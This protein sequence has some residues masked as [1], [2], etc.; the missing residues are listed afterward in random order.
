MGELRNNR[1]VRVA[2]VLAVAVA[3][4]GFL[5]ISGGDDDQGA[6]GPTIVT[7][8]ELEEIAEDAERPIYWAGERPGTL[9]V[10]ERTEDGL[11]YVRYVAADAEAYDPSKSFL[12][13]GTYTV[14]DAVKDLEEVAEGENTI[15]NDLPDG[16]LVVINTERPSSAY[17]AYPGAE[18]QVEVYAPDPRRAF[19]IATSGEI[20]PIG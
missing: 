13:V 17:V 14:D 4:I 12:T 19:R 11:V 2:A 20:V 5:L 10:Y 9:L 15:R 3:V 8:D 16:G 18:E 7:T 6:E 1:Q